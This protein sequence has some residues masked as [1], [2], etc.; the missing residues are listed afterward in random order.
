M[1]LE[2][3]IQECNHPP[4]FKTLVVISSAV[5]CETY[6]IKCSKCGAQLEPPKTDC[7]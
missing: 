4:E 3:D 2:K 6:I 7:A 1:K 5:N